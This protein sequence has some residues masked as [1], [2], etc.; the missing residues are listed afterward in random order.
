M[1]VDTSRIGFPISPPCPACGC[2]RVVK[3][4]SIHNGKKK[5]R[6]RSCG[7]QFVENNRKKIA[8]SRGLSLIDRLL[9][10]RISL[11]G[12]AR[13]LAISQTSIQKYVHEKYKLIP[14]QVSVSDKPKGKS[15]L[16]Y[17]EL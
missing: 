16:E 1:L 17:D 3:N 2:F 10:E 4:V 13:A 15:T 7:W 6:C 5:Y 12:I 11:A 9:L 14:R 8:S